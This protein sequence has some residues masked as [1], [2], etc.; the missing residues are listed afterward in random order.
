MKYKKIITVA[1]IA[2]IALG[3]I[4]W[5]IYQTR[6]LRQSEGWKDAHPTRGQVDRWLIQN[7]NPAVYQIWN[8]NP[9]LNGQEFGA[10]TINQENYISYLSRMT[11][12]VTKIAAKTFFSK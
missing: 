3:I 12:I 10:W 6:Q 11:P 9:K 5:K 7:F 2:A 8:K 4:G 1:A